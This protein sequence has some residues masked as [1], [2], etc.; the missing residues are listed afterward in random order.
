M[1]YNILR[2]QATLYLQEKEDYSL[3][4]IN[5]LYLVYKKIYLEKRNSTMINPPNMK[6][7]KEP[8][9]TTRV[10]AQVDARTII[11]S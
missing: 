1:S 6:K 8:P 10:C 2:I 5:E 4:D 7:N 3:N 11:L 9:S